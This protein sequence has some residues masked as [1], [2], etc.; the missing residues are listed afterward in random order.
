MWKTITNEASDK[1]NTHYS[2]LTLK[3]LMKNVAKIKFDQKLYIIK[4]TKISVAVKMLI[5]ITQ[6][7]C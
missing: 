7:N 6:H 3:L 2:N 1:Q 4:Y 5:I